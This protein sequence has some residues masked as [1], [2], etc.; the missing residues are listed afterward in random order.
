MKALNTNTR[1][2]LNTLK[3]QAGMTLT[4]SLLVLSVG[5]LVAVLAYGGYK[6]ATS[7][8]KVQSQAKGTVQLV[9][10]IK[11]VFGTSASYGATAG[12]SMYTT[13]KNAKIL[14]ADFKDNGTAFVNAWGGTVIPAVGDPNTAQFTITINGVPAEGCIEFLNGINSAASGGLTMGG[15]SVKTAAG[16]FN[17]GAAAT[18]CANSSSADPT[19]QIA[20]LTAQ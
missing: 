8:V 2:K 6:M 20:I 12:A 11:Q 5:A 14:P 3:Q 18:Q 9:G 16:E 17:T 1:N 4:E 15:T 13:V 10:K 7:D 19:T